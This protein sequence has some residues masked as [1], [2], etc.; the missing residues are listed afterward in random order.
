MRRE[1]D[2]DYQHKVSLLK[3]IIFIFGYGVINANIEFNDK[4]VI[5]YFINK[6]LNNLYPLENIIH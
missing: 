2:R 5:F 6:I 1:V 3:S 4:C